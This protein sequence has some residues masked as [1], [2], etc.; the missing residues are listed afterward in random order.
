[1]KST[2]LTILI[3]LL[4]PTAALSESYLDRFCSQRGEAD[5]FGQEE[6]DI[7]KDDLKNR[8]PNLRATAMDTL[9][10]LGKRA[11]PAIPEMVLL[12]DEPNGEAQL[13]NIAAVAHLKEWAVPD[14]VAA[15]ENRNTNIRRGACIALGK[16]GAP[17]RSAL[18]SLRKLLDEPGFDVSLAAERALRQIKS[19]P[20]K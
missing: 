16:I 14:L 15:L 7:L 18:P 4:S 20:K 5:R 8:D 10:C 1:M 11:L 13:N 6:I 17:A 2:A 9:S 3:I 19:S 12:F